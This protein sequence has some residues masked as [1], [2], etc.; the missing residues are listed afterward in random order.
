MGPFRAFVIDSHVSRGGKLWSADRPRA[1]LGLARAYAAEGDGENGRKAYEDFF[2]TGK[3]ADPDIPI[4]RRAKAEYKKLAATTS[5]VASA[6]GKNNSP[7]SLKVPQ[8]SKMRFWTRGRGL[9]KSRSRPFARP[10][11]RRIQVG[12]LLLVWRNISTASCVSPVDPFTSPRT[13]REA[14]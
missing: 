6:S 14:T 7:V 8:K 5:A 1:Q 11:S 9:P 3:D 4:L 12:R 2:T 13:T 10:L